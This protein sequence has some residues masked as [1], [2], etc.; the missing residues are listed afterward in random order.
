MADKEKGKKDTVT[1][2]EE[3]EKSTK[4][5]LTEFAALAWQQ[6]TKDYG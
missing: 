6:L 3:K 1:D 2:S 5:E 4:L